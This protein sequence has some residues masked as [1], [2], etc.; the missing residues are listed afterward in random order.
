VYGRQRQ[1]NFLNSCISTGH[2]SF[3]AVIPRNCKTPEKKQIQ[4]LPQAIHATSWSFGAFVAVGTFE[5]ERSCHGS[6]LQTKLGAFYTRHY[7]R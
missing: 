7:K 5:K 1:F 6:T 3:I 4:K 2:S